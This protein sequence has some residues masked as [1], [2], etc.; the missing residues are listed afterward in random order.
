MIKASAAVDLVE[1]W[2]LPPFLH[3]L[4][5]VFLCADHYF[6]DHQITCVETADVLTTFYVKP[7]Q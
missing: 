2:F 4:G 6:A 3:L 5:D 7:D 1:R